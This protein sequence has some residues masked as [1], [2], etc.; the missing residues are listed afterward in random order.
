MFVLPHFAFGG[1][2]FRS[3]ITLRLPSN[4]NVRNALQFRFSDTTVKT[5]LA[6]DLSADSLLYSPFDQNQGA[7]NDATNTNLTSLNN[8]GPKLILEY[9]AN[10]SVLNYR[11]T[12]EYYNGVVNSMGGQAAADSFVRYYIAPGVNHCSGGPGA[13]N[14][15]LLAALDSW[16]DKGTAPGTLTANKIVPRRMSDS[17][18]HRSM[19]RA[20]RV[21]PA[22]KL[23]DMRRWLS[24]LLLVFMPFQFSWAA[25]TAYCEHESGAR[26]QHFGH[27]EHKHQQPAGESSEASKVK[28]IA[29]LD[30]VDCHFHCQCAVALPAVLMMPMATG[31]QPLAE[32]TAAD[33]IAPVLS[34]PERPQWVAHA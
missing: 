12:T 15:D 8:S 2:E 34:R 26:A 20:T 16:V 1:I 3:A 9:A 29:A 14:A 30:V 22:D 23:A 31:S 11:A 5:Y 24:I 28:L 4:G 32:W 19:D 18:C 17:S 25:M 27:H 33:A 21:N 6:R 13:D 7:L 10:D